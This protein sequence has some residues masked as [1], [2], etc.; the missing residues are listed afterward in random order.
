MNR[1]TLDEIKKMIQKKRSTIQATARTTKSLR[2]GNPSVRVPASIYDGGNGITNNDVASVIAPSE[3]NFE[4]DDLV[5]NSQAYRRVFAQARARFGTAG[6]QNSS[7]QQT[8]TAVVDVSVSAMTKPSDDSKPQ[9]ASAV[10]EELQALSLKYSVEYSHK[11]SLAA[12]RTG[13]SQV[14][15]SSLSKADAGKD[16]PDITRL[17][18]GLSG[19]KTQDR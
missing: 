11:K 10:T 5:I 16:V 13:T 2:S 6:D 18:D 15:G 1:N 12:N 7:E 4:F 8:T 14:T 19:K 9:L 17:S 3:I